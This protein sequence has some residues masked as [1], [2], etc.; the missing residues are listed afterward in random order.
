MNALIKISAKEF[1]A[2]LFK[3]LQ[4][5]F[6]RFQNAELTISLHEKRRTTEVSEDKSE[7]EKR[8]LNSVKE[9]E[10]GK[11]VE[12]TMDSLKKYVDDLVKQ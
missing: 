2:E 10:E 6:K 11:Y 3:N 1:N 5:I 9:M 7:Y 4:E 8:L 12:F